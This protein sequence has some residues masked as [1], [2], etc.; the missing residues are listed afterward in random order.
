MH[1]LFLLYFMLGLG[2]Q[3]ASR[4]PNV[5]LIFTD[6]LGYADI[7]AFGGRT[8]TPHLNR[9][10][11]EGIRFTDFQVAQ[12]VC[13]ASRAA[14]LT[15]CLPNRIGI[16]GALGPNAKTGLHPDE[17]TLAEVMQPRGYATGMFGKW[18]LG[19]DWALLPRRQGFGEYAGLACSN[20]MWPLH[21]TA[22]RNYPPLLFFVNDGVVQ[23][24]PSQDR[25]TGL[26]AERAVRFIGANR[27]R[28]F[29]LY[30]AHTMPHVPLGVSDAWRGRTGL[31]LYADVIA[32]I[33]ASVGAILDALDEHGLARD[34]LVIFTSDN[35]PWLS[36]GD[37]AGSAG[38]LR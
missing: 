9:L 32:E 11:R 4:P 20:D 29:F 31:G 35:G 21:P 26:Y 25:F 38:H 7:E 12:A 16:T 24:T 27:N 36:Y 10:A 34:T 2:A 18:H 15:G 37:H 8:P 13:S 23:P 19:D 28:P 6:D 14:L 22:G 33:D 30:V 1:R 3:A 17:V 5:V